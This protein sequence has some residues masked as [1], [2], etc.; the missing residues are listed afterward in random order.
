MSKGSSVG[1]GGGP[2]V[3]AGEGLDRPKNEFDRKEVN[4]LAGF[5]R[6]AT[7]AARGGGVKPVAGLSYTLL[8][9]SEKPTG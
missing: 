5:A 6:A 1:G 7:G 2:G 9:T 4:A 3:G 8:P